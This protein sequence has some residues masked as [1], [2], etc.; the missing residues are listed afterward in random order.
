MAGAGANPGAFDPILAFT[1]MAKYTRN[2]QHNRNKKRPVIADPIFFVPGFI[3]Y[4]L[5]SEINSSIEE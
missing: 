5:N 1:W 4:T 3:Y 2:P